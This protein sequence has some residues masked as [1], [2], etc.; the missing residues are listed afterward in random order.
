MLILFPPRFFTSVKKPARQL[1]ADIS[2]HSTVSLKATL[3]TWTMSVIP[4]C[5]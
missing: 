4:S 3:S 1:C 5:L 2:F